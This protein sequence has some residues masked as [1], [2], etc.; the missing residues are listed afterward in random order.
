MYEKILVPIDG[1]ETSAAGLSEA[2]KIA[3]S[4]QSEIR[5][6]HILHDL[7]YD[8]GYNSRLY[9]ADALEVLRKTGREILDAAEATAR[10]EGIKSTSVL[11]ESVGGPAAELIIAEAKAWSANLLVLGTHGRRGLARIV[12]GS[13]AEEVVRSCSVP[14]LLVRGARPPGAIAQRTVA[15]VG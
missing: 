8:Y 2:I 11:L 15:A 6:V 3:K 4:L 7:I 9:A 5:L 13:D 12:M 10:R 14:V 1:S